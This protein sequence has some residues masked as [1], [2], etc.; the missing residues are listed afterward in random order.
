MRAARE[1]ACAVAKREREIECVREQVLRVHKARERSKHTVSLSVA[2]A[3]SLSCA[4][5]HIKKEYNLLFY[6]AILILLHII[7]LPNICTLFIYF[8]LLYLIYIK[9][10]LFQDYFWYMFSR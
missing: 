8:L 9:A 3:S 7:F 4:E 5:Q 10:N 2:L 1:R 6:C